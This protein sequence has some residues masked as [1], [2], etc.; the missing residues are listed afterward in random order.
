METLSQKYQIVV[1]ALETLQEALHII[2]LNKYEE[3]YATLRDSVIKRFEYSM[4]TFWKY[5]KEYLELEHKIIVS[6]NSPK[7]IFRE[8][9]NLKIITQEEFEIFLDLV[10]D[11]NRTSHSYNEFIAEEISEDVKKYFANMRAIIFRLKPS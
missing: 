5:L 1:Q 9:L 3:I 6:I 7:A 10:D 11:R 2:T 8:C 4:D